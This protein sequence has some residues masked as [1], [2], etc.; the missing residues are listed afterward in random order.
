M[1]PLS[2][3]IIA[4]AS[5][6]WIKYLDTLDQYKKDKGTTRI[7]V[8][9]FVAGMVSVIPTFGLYAI[10]P[11]WSVSEQMGVF[12]YYF[13]V[14]GVTEETCKYLLLVAVVA[15]FKSI[16]EPQDGIIQGAAVGL[17]FSAV[18]NVTY[19]LDYGPINTVMRS[20]VASGGHMIYGALVGFFLGGAVYANLEV[21][22]K[23][24]K[25]LAFL[26]VLLVAVI[27]ALYNSA[28]SWSAQNSRL[29]NLSVAIDVVGLILAV[30][31]FRYMV[32]HSPY[33]VFP[34]SQSRDAIA[35][36]KRG[37]RLNPTSYVLNRRLILYMLADRDFH[38][39]LEPIR[40]C[41][42]RIKRQ[43][44]FDAL[45]GVVMLGLGKDD[46]G[47]AL[48]TKAHSKLNGKQRRRI[49]Q[50]LRSILGDGALRM[51][52]DNILNPHVFTPNPHLRRE[53]PV[54]KGRRSRSRREAYLEHGTAPGVVGI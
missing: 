19:A 1:L 54:A 39:A 37:L 12:L 16:K 29:Q 34:Y 36:V 24:A 49:S 33:R 7:I 14:V 13:F 35:A 51:R 8:I 46:R 17:G 38:G 5:F 28:L 26:S 48:L 11:Y 47:F 27:H 52:A 42:G 31:A 45:E 32:S 10:N 9:A 23:R 40:V 43:G 44:V 30:A 2:L 41:R 22:D 50:V 21:E 4:F 3:A 15:V 20:I 53:S 6:L 18:E 25:Q